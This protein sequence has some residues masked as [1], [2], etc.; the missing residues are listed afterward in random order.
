MSV[1]AR[2]CLCVCER[3]TERETADKSER[4]TDEGMDEGVRLSRN[5]IL[6][7]TKEVLAR[8][9]CLKEISNALKYR[10][11]VI[12]VYETNEECGGVSGIFS[13]FYGTELEKVFHEEDCKWLMKRAYVPFHDR[14]QHV[15]VMLS[16][17]KCK[18]GILDQMELGEAANQVRSCALVRP[19]V[20]A[21]SLSFSLV[22]QCAPNVLLLVYVVRDVVT[23]PR[24]CRRVWFICWE[25]TLSTRT[26]NTLL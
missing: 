18:N 12:L 14:G 5:F 10:K 3:E 1:Y 21:A 2:A 11:N 6:F 25:P 9:Y 19:V 20:R 4:A 22:A 8:K 15:D 23:W 16:D 7:L 17:P 13:K 26:T 24:I